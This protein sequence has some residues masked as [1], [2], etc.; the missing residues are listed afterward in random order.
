MIFHDLGAEYLLKLK[1]TEFWCVFNIFF[2]IM[3]K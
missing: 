1:Y 3:I 2:S